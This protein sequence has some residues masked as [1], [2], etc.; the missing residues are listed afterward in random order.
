MV[1]LLKYFLKQALNITKAIMR[2]TTI[3]A[4]MEKGLS[5]IIKAP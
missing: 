2:S 1:T 5:Q 4:M 3:M